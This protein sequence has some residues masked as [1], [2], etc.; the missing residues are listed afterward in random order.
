M[1]ELRAA[2]E[3]IKELKIWVRVFF[4][5]ERDLEARTSAAREALNSGIEEASAAMSNSPSDVTLRAIYDHMVH[6]RDSLGPQPLLPVYETTRPFA[7]EPTRC[8]VGQGQRLS[9]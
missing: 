4:S 2:Q 1:A 9:S 7:V 3:K 5:H 6:A 8:F